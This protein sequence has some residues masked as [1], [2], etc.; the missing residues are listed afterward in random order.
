MSASPA[1]PAQNLRPRK[2]WDL[3][4]LG[5]LQGLVGRCP[6]VV[7]RTGSP[8]TVAGVGTAQDGLRLWASGSLE[9]C[10]PS[11]TSHIPG[12]HPGDARVPT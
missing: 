3:G 4:A 7:A 2:G 6:Q 11:V 9:S 12:A 8:S 5:S 1:Q 10:T